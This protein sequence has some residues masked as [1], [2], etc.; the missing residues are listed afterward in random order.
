MENR[1]R[2]VTANVYCYRDTCNVYIVRSGREALLIDFGAGDVLP[3][4]PELGVDHV[5]HVLMTHHHRDQ[6]QGLPRAA[7]AG[8]AVWV[9]HT[10]QELF[11][12]VDAHW[13][14]RPIYNNYDVRQDRFSLLESVPIM[15][16]LRDY[17]GYRFGNHTFTVVPTPGHTTGSITLMAE[18]D[19]RRMA[20]SGDLIMAPGKV[21]S[22]AATQWTYNG[23]EGA[24][25]SVASIVDLQKRRP[26]LLLPSHGEAMTDPQVA[27]ALL[28]ERLAEL[29]RRRRQNPRLF[30][31]LERP[32]TAVLPHL[33][34]N[35]TSMANSYVLLSQSGRALLIDYGYD[36][37]T[38]VAPGA[39]RASRRPWLYSL[40]ALKDQYGVQGI[41]VVVPTH[42]H[43]DH[44]AGLNLLRSVE[45]TQV[46]AAEN[47]AP[48]LTCPGRY[49]LP[50][51]WYD[52]IPVDRVLPLNRP[53]QWQE[54][55][56]TL[57]EL[58]GHARYAV[59]V[60]F[61]VD[62]RRVLATGDQYQGEDGLQW[63]YVYQNRFRID[64]YR[65]SAELYGRLKPDLILSGHWDPLW[66]TPEYLTLLV[67]GGQALEQL[68][69]DLL[70]LEMLDLGAEGVA[71][72]IE[73]Y[74]AVGR[75]GER[76]AFELELL[77]PFAHEEKV[78]VTLI[79]PDGWLVTPAQLSQRLPGHGTQR[80]RFD[81]VPPAGLQVRR[82]RLAADLTIGPQRFG[83][84]A[85]A[86]VTL[87]GELGPGLGD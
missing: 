16:T 56:L 68:H 81:V 13:Q 65:A 83:Q 27:M 7:A 41:D 62:G 2:P 34:F 37:I 52:P 10:E 21:W 74:Q 23:A 25:L 12:G 31:F 5:S 50:C 76:L 11:S 49:D 32:Y 63:N 3:L 54:Y 67:E 38:G 73:P 69:R 18:I 22:L 39:D 6:A 30:T 19:G 64:D 29:L 85:E 57:Y 9:P 24:A 14:A 45:G 53:L 17:A 8:I 70:P 86:L 15:G 72:R 79:V 78:D 33:L 71:A 40:P 58:P 80:L 66:V 84:Q 46:W 44:V 77:N 75:G 47:F 60:F 61:E 55:T 36:F 51:L 20:F 28:I 35:Q 1:L 59:A 87:L 43:D 48:I 26:D 82:A 4:L 42:Y